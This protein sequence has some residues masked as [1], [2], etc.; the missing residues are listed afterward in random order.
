MPIDFELHETVA[1][2][3]DFVHMFAESTLRPIA[4]EADEKGVLP[5]ETI[6][7]LGQLAG[8][9]ASMMPEERSDGDEERKSI[10]S[11]LG[12]VGSEELA[13][14]D[15]A[16]LLNIP[17]PGLAA[18]S[19]LAAGTPE[20]KKEFLDDVFNVQSDEP[21]FG[22]LAVTEPQAGSDVS[23]VQT[24]ARRDGDEWVLNGQ[25]VYCTNGARAEIVVVNATV[26]KSLGRQ[27]QKF[28]VIK[29]GT[30]GFNILKIEKKLGLT[31]SET[32]AFSLDD[33]RIPFNHILGGEAALEPQGSGFKGTMK[34]FDSSRP[35]VAAMGLG[36]GRA[37]YE[38]ARDWVAAELP[39]TTNFTRKAAIEQKLG[40]MKRELTAARGLVWKAAWMADNKI[41]NSKEASM[42]KAYAPQAAMRACIGAIQIMGPEGYSKEHLVEKWFRDIKVYD[43]FEG[44][45]QIQRIVISRSILG[46]LD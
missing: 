41:P 34:T 36:I 21:R 44:T 27:G 17:G 45:G 25:K 6:K 9:R 7:Q 15:P 19:I 3:R 10:G 39:M 4:R 32:A 38:Y 2:V 40:T 33:C 23:N 22:A 14:G 20:Q 46:R 24:T 18:P 30:P 35:S 1:A 11:M 12:V 43:I 13:W 31:A 37:S 29:K 42:S 8:N 5:V 16:V 26:D 28:F